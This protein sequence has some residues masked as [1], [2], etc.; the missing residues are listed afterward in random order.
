[1]RL[2]NLV[3]ADGAARDLLGMRGCDIRENV[4]VDGNCRSVIAA[5]K[6]GD[7]SNLHL[8][9]PRGGKATFEIGTQLASAVQV[10]AHVRADAN[11]GFG[12]P[13]Q[14]KMGIETRDTVDLVER[15]LGAL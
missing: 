12:W 7:V 10:A 11:L 15:R 4:I 8:A 2:V 14:M 1:M 6:T 3:A 9:S 5:S 13:Y